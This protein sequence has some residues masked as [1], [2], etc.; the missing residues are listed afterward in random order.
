MHMRNSRIL[1]PIDVYGPKNVDLKKGG[2]FKNLASLDVK[3][4]LKLNEIPSG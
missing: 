4:E 2:V 1:N 3:F